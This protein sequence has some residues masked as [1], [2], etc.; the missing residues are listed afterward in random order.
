MLFREA[1]PIAIN[2]NCAYASLN[3]CYPVINFK[4]NIADSIQRM[5]I[6]VTK[7]SP[8]IWKTANS[9]LSCM[10]FQVFM[11]LKQT[12]CKPLASPGV[13]ISALGFLSYYTRRLSPGNPANNLYMSPGNPRNNSYK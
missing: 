9:V 5:Y 12:V 10:I 3:G 8:I 1:N 7:Y 11:F 4:L 13:D 2:E 6:F